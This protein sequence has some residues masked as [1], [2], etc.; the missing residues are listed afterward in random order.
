M[1]SFCSDGFSRTPLS[2]FFSKA[3]KVKKVVATNQLST[4]LFRH[5]TALKALED[6]SIN[7]F[8]PPQLPFLFPLTNLRTLS[9]RSTHF[10]DAC[11]V[12]LRSLSSLEHLDVSGTTI[13]SPG[14]AF[15]VKTFIN[16]KS[17]ILDSCSS[18]P[19]AAFSQIG[20]LTQLKKLSFFACLLSNLVLFELFQ[21]LAD[22][23][24]LQ[25]MGTDVTAGGLI[26]LHHLQKLKHLGLPEQ[27]LKGFHYLM[28]LTCLEELLFP[29]GTALPTDF[30]PHLKHLTRLRGLDLFDA[31][32]TDEHLVS[33]TSL[34]KLEKLIVGGVINGEGLIHLK[35][36]HNLIEL[37]LCN[38]T[39][40][41]NLSFLPTSLMRLKMMCDKVDNISH[42]TNL[43]RLGCIFPEGDNP[44]LGPIQ[45]FKFLE[46]VAF[47]QLP[48]NQLPIV[49]SWTQIKD[50][51]L[52]YCGVTTQD[53][54][55]LSSM[56]NLTNLSMVGG[57]MES[58]D[59]KYFDKMTKLKYLTL[60]WMG[61]ITKQDLIRFKH[62]TRLK[63]VMLDYQ[64][65]CHQ[66]IQL[67]NQ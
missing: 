59:L 49:A 7:P 30:L 58:E 26:H 13:A 40:P 23:E 12:Q 11:L 36:L 48:N 28:G 14:L 29:R 61:N 21:N 54:E 4:D 53:L 55:L 2:C 41:S 66:Q 24:F 64:K 62:L 8:S 39:Y 20:A 31:D 67:M 32:T 9:V 46:S 38:I 6:L 34:I 50:L 60:S 35:P 37:G 45:H 22:L 16:L 27:T 25:L 42:L 17:L 52:S 19:Q 63:T 18:I 47:N 1:L 57:E 43:V 15:I 5:L 3:P 56:T 65:V 10:N 44:S 51:S 33:L